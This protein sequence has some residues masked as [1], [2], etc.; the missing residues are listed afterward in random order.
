MRIIFIFIFEIIEIFINNNLKKSFFFK[1]FFLSIQSFQTIR[2]FK[3][4]KNIEDNKDQ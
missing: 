4:I 3:D 1:L 2:Y